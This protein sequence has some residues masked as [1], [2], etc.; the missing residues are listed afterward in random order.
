MARM[1]QMFS[2]QS[3]EERLE[4]QMAADG[5]RF[6][7]GRRIRCSLQGYLAGRT[8]PICVIGDIGG[9]NAFVVLK[10]ALCSLW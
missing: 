6:F 9:S 3:R 4:P 2:T 5:R 10:N 7:R 8:L 1:T